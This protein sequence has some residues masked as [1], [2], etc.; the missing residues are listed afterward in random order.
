MNLQSLVVRSLCTCTRSSPAR[1]T[2]AMFA[3]FAPHLRQPLPP[4]VYTR[5]LVHD[6]ASTVNMTPRELEAFIAS[7]ASWEVAR[8]GGEHDARK[9]ARRGVELLQKVGERREDPQEYP[10]SLLYEAD[11]EHMFQLRASCCFT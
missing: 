3:L 11:L 7:D 2:A 5:G 1:T 6:F 10:M 8:E 9:W 4:G